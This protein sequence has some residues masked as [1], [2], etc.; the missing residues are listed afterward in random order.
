MSVV[1]GSGVYYST[2]ELQWTKYFKTGIF[3]IFNSARTVRGHKQISNIIICSIVC[4]RI[5]CYHL[6]Y[7]SFIN[8][9]INGYNTV[10]YVL[11]ENNSL[12]TN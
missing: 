11:I 8:Q 6:H 5:K 4:G 7:K 10:S 2:G 12:A 1:Q 3:V 9:F